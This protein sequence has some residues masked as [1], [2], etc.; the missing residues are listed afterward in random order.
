MEEN[1][2]VTLP[3][4]GASITDDPLLA[5]LRDGARR[6]LMQAIEAEVEAFL[7]THAERVDEQGRRRLVRNGHAPERQI[8][9]L[10]RAAIKWPHCGPAPQGA[11]PWRQG[12]RTDPLHLGG[13]TG[14]SAADPQY[15][16]ALALALP[17]G[18][19]HGPVRRSPD[20]AARTQGAWLV[21]GDRAP[22]D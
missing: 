8:Q 2:V 18:R 10:D 16:G 17:E 11:R 7:T 12:R 6:M 5:V 19:V 3:R 14:L 1:T 15:R 21:S 22:S 9:T 20:G 4:P 13:L